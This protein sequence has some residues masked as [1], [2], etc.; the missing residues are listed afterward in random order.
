[1]ADHENARRVILRIVLLT[2]LILLLGACAAAPD[3]EPGQQAAPQS[4]DPGEAIP[5]TEAE[6]ESKPPIPEGYDLGGY[7]FTIL[8]GNIG[9]WMYTYRVTADEETGEVLNDAIFKRN[10][11]TE[12]LLNM[13]ITAI[14]QN[15]ARDTAE[16]S[17]KGGD[18]AYDLVLDNTSPAFKMALGG[19]V[20]SYDSIDSIDTENPWWERNSL[21]DFSIANHV[22][23]AVSLFD[24]THYD[25]VRTLMFNKGMRE[26]FGLEDPYEL[27][28]E[29]RWTLDQMEKM[30]L[31]VA[32]DVNGNG[33]W[34][35]EDRYGYTSWSRNGC[36]MYVYAIGGKLSVNKDENDLPFFDLDDIFYYDRFD[37]V[38]NLLAKEGYK[39]N[40]GTA[41]NHGG[42]DYFIAG[43]TLFFSESLGNSHSLRDMDTDFG[44]LP[45]PKYNEEQKEYYSFG[46]T[47]YCELVPIT[48][49]DP[50][51]T[52][53]VMETLAW[54][55]QDTIVPAF[56]D[57][58]LNGK[59]IR[60][61][62]S[63]PML[64]II[65]D[66]LSY[67]SQVAFDQC[68]TQVTDLIWGGKGGFASYFAKYSRIINKEIDKAIKAYSEN[69][70]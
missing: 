33:Q 18:D 24:T 14:D 19:S 59:V 56:Y 16:R 6:T 42:L 65:F 15:G 49:S 63:G 69:N 20:L 29:D 53:Y 11:A 32:N 67:P 66:T 38:T 60:D 43:Q 31:A 44:F 4:A 13:K 28:R 3:E 17:I 12:D 57:V 21:R 30:G 58:T 55:S 52:G 62:E 27:V 5:E 50:E 68:D 9:D 61:T 1:M 35:D 40:F 48:A 34:D 25:Y 47:P 39:A 64:D 36:E 54:A 51:R 45:G 46:G 7:T 8:N 2:F 22:Y 41:G 10:L 23:Y 70:Q 37:A 26:E